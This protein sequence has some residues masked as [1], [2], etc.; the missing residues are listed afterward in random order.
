MKMLIRFSAIGNT[1]DYII[2]IIITH[3][4][5]TGKFIKKFHILMQNPSLLKQQSKKGENDLI[6]NAMINNYIT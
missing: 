1:P 2:F 4:K 5:F 6:K 3:E